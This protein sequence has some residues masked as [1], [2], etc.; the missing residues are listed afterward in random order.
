MY[1]R[2]INR[3]IHGVQ[4]TKLF[5]LTISDVSNNVTVM[6]VSG[7]RSAAAAAAAAADDDDDDVGDVQVKVWFQNRRTKHKRVQ[8]DDVTD[9]VTDDDDTARAAAE[10]TSSDDELVNVDCSSSTSPTSSSPHQSVASPATLHQ[11]LRFT[12][13]SP[14]PLDHYPQH[15]HH[16]NSTPN[17]NP[18][19]DDRPPLT[20]STIHHNFRSAAALFAH[21]GDYHHGDRMTMTSSFTG[22]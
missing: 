17:I 21:H 10:T 12:Q 20:L 13:S 11:E 15:T 8:S 7:L 9:D 2:L 1:T 19:S 18:N 6:T 16:P 3:C 22:T 5:Q 4:I 14:L